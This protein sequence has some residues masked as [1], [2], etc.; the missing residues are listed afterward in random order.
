M[1]KI[2][3]V[4]KTI[5]EVA[6]LLNLFDSKTGKLSTHTIRFW[7]KEFKQVKPYIFSGKRRYYDENL[8]KILKKIHFLL[9]V[10]GMTIKGAKKVLDNNNSNLDEINNKT[11]N[12]DLIK[13]K[14]N[15][16]SNIIKKIKNN[17]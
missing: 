5:G 8:I 7:E 9:K 13:T 3:K 6:E 17:G 16:I 4:Y 12:S 11:I 2:K 10:R 1:N 15:R 14:L